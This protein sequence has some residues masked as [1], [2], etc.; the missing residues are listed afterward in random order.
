MLTN[1]ISS[2]NRSISL[3][4]YQ[5]RVVFRIDYGGEIKLEIN[6]TKKY[7][8]GEWINVAAARQF[9]PKGGTENGSLVVGKEIHTGSPTAPV[10]SDS[11]PNL[12]NVHYYLGGLPPGF[13]S[14]TSKAPGAD[15]AFLGCMKDVTI[16][17][18]SYD[19]MDSSN[20]YG[21]EQTCREVIN[22]I[23]FNGIGYA[24][25]PSES[26]RK[27]GNFGFVFRTMQPDCVLLMAGYPET[28][29]ENFDERDLRGNYSVW[30]KD[31][32]VNLYVDGGHGMVRLS[33]NSTVNDGEFHS[34]TVVRSNR[35][36]Q[37]RIDD[38]LEKMDS[39]PPT[40]MAINLPEEHGGLFLGGT[41]THSIAFDSIPPFE[42]IGLIGTIKD[43]VFNN[44][45]L[46]LNSPVRVDGV[47]MGRM[48]PQ[49][50]SQN[51]LSNVLMKTEPIGGGFEPV[52]EGCERVSERGV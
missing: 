35:K 7:N 10:N 47:E 43:V 11:L 27:R 17:Q 6:S 24:E 42:K 12:S 29:A 40:T 18:E 38:Q 34:V 15:Q 51:G 45:T 16:N 48:G 31:G 8:T 19:P 22:R 50:G 49:M 32:R 37:L 20:F 4:L 13:K 1:S 46:Q 2:Q 26:I 21:V 28:V 3:T 25:Y 44:A 9:H 14:G 52:A 30:L 39:L 41:P 36:V 33:S 5:G 23:G